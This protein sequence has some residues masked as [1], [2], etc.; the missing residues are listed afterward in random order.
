VEPV[1]TSAALRALAAL[2]EPTRRALYDVVRTAEAPVTRETA[3]EAVGISRKL[4][5]FHLDK[6]TEATLLVAAYETTARTRQFGR[7]PKAYRRAPE[8]LHISIPERHPEVLA[9]LL[10]EAVTAARAGETPT[11]AALRVAYESGQRLGAQTRAQ[12]RPGRLGPERALALAASVLAAR[13]FEPS[14]ESATCMRLRNCPYLP[15]S[16]EATELVCGINHRHLVGMLD[17]LQAPDSVAA[18]LVPRAGHC[19]VQVRA[20]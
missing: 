15:L 13:G 12:T 9:R 7:P 17:G 8:E 1:D 4:A 16:A 11:D 14:R 2:D 5:A 6:L 18:E 10:L 19:C 3:A 20:S